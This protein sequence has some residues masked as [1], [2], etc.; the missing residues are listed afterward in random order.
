MRAVCETARNSAAKQVASQRASAAMCGSNVVNGERSSA[1]DSAAI[2]SDARSIDS[3][4]NRFEPN[5]E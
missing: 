4:R 3:E 1:S 5:A 2:E